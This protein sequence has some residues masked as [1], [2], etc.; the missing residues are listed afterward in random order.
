MRRRT[1]ITAVAAPF[2][3]FFSIPTFGT[4]RNRAV[5]VRSLHQCSVEA[6]G[7]RR[8]LRIGDPICVGNT[9]DVPADAKLRLRMD[10]G[11]VISLASGS[12][13]TIKTFG[14][15]ASGQKRDARPTLATGL[16]RAVV[17]LLDE[18][19][20]FEVDY[21]PEPLRCD[22]PHGSWRRNPARCGSACPQAGWS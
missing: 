5:V 17:S 6:G 10:D 1:V 21:P 3:G 13:L 11:S 16:L 22:R 12:R 9:V 4:A 7:Q 19:S 8:E 15:D 14:V 18:P 20:I 2:L